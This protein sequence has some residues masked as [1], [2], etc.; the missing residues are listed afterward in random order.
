MVDPFPDPMKQPMMRRLAQRPFQVVGLQ[1]PGPSV[2]LKSSQNVQFR[3]R[4]RIM[5]R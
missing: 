1:L 2:K 3:N 5:T 4:K